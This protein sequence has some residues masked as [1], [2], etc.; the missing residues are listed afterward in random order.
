V[1]VCPP[2]FNGT[3]DIPMF[4][5]ESSE[6]AHNKAKVLITRTHMTIFCATFI[7]LRWASINILDDWRIALVTIFSTAKQC[8]FEPGLKMPGL[9][10]AL[11][12]RETSLLIDD[13]EVA[14][15]EPSGAAAI[16][17]LN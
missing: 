14:M 13:V 2:G 12:V 16:S 17:V 6:H 7:D 10:G 9:I 5:P 15:A 1:P 8:S 11:I 3:P 4:Q